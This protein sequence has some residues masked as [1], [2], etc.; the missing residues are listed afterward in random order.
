MFADD[1]DAV[2]PL[3]RLRIRHPAS[4]LYT[5]S[6]YGTVF[7]M[8]QFLQTA[9]G[10]GPLGAGLRL[11]PWTATLFVVA[12]IAGGLVNRLGERPLIVVGL[13]LQGV[14][15]AWIGLIAAPDL[16]YVKLVAPLIV[17]GVGV[18]MAMPAAQNVVVSS[19]AATELGKA[20]GIFNMYRFLGRVSGIAI[21]VV[22]F[23]GSGSFDSPQAFSAGFAP[24][25]SVT[26]ALALVGAVAG[27]WQPGRGVGVLVH[28][29]ATA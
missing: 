8:A 6:L 1:A 9:L 20:S 16:T 29:Q 14:G 28:A 7:F 4:F 10:Y 24:A 19:V 15:M 26:A 18:S 25:L 21:V 22:V 3:P 23:A 27:M 5:A 11:L 12:P 2:L 13:L 17:A